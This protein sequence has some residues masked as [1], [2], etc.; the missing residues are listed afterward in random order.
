MHIFFSTS[1]YGRADLDKKSQAIVTAVEKTG[2]T[3]EADH[4]FSVTPE[5]M[6]TWTD[7]QDLA[8]HKKVFERIKKADALFAE[9]SR[10]STSVGYLIAVAA[11][12]GKP[13]VVFYNGDQE[14]HLFKSLE[15]LMDRFQV[16]RYSNVE[17]L[18]D[19]VPYMIDFIEGS[20]DVRFNF[21]VSSSISSYLDWVSKTR[22][23][24]RSVYLRRLI[25]EDM[26][27]E[28]VAV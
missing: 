19:E 8:Y 27:K 11:Q 9:V 22:K 16:V 24:P 5:E 3:I 14:P 15:K 25:D 21:F 23:I 17:E 6:A 2:H 18:G 10:P 26:Q 7:E 13:V 28:R 20:Q 1:V 12:A 4:I